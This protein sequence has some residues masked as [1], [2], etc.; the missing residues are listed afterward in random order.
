MVIGLILIAMQL[1]ANMVEA[2]NWSVQ[3][4]GLAAILDGVSFVD[5]QH[6]WVSGAGNSVGSEVLYTSDAGAHWHR[7]T[8]S[9][10]SLLYLDIAMNSAKSGVVSGLGLGPVAGTDYTTNGTVFMPSEEIALESES[11]SVE[12]IVGVPLGYGVTGQYGPKNG[13]AITTDGGHT[14][15]MYD[16]GLDNET[17]LT[18]YGAFPS[19]T[20]WYLTGGAWPGVSE[21]RARGRVENFRQLTPRISLHVDPVTRSAKPVFDFSE[22]HMPKQTPEG[23]NGFYAAVAKTTD[24]GKTWKTVFSNVNNFYPNQISCPTVNDCWFLGESEGP[25]NNPG[26]RIIHTSNGGKTWTTQWHSTDPEY[27]LMALNML[28]STEGWAAGGVLNRSIEGEW[29]YTSDGGKTWVNNTVK[30]VYGNDMSF[31]KSGNSFVGW[32]TAFTAEGISALV[33]YK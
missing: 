28:S 3:A 30:G 6:G 21:Q 27:S 5:S 20:T 17:T 23:N 14:F 9:G 29:M 25:S 33:Q 18:R 7:A 8:D 31:V 11:Q 1:G 22:R 24:G 15:T 13:V 12:G 16:C 32:A 4:M 10:A 2:G 26:A 19:A